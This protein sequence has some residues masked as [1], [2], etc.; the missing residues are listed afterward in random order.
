MSQERNFRSRLLPA[1]VPA[2]LAT[3][4]AAEKLEAVKAELLAEGW[5]WVTV[6]ERLRLWLG[7]GFT[8]FEAAPVE[9]SETE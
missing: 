3:C 5:A 2:F 9:L 7:P 8:R 4:L 1:I 6:V